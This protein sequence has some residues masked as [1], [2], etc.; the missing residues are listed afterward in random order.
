MPFLI[1]RKS[2]YKRMT[3]FI[4]NAS[5]MLVRNLSSFYFSIFLYYQNATIFKEYVL[6]RCHVVFF[7][8]LAEPR[9]E[10]TCLRGFLPGTIQTGL[11]S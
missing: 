9:H 1:D 2:C 11:L 3:A 5:S 10:K 8:C 6:I 4:I 7:S